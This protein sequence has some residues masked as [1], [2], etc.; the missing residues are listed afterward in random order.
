[1]GYLMA[2]STVTSCPAIKKSITF[3]TFHSSTGL[4]MV[5]FNI[6]MIDM[7]AKSKSQSERAHLRCLKC[8]SFSHSSLEGT[9]FH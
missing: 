6:L 4:Y 1:M 8:A 3:I 5:F 7:Q 2:C 9:Q